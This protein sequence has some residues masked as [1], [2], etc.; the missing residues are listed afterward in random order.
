V[1]IVLIAVTVAVSISIAAW[2]GS[3]TFSFGETK[4]DITVSVPPFEGASHAHAWIDGGYVDTVKPEVLPFNLTFR[5]ALKS[6]VLKVEYFNR[7]MYSTSGNV[8]V[9]QFLKIG[10]EQQFIIELKGD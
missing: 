3:L 9:Y 8:T 6:F 2:M 10:S 7:T 1:A 5:S 4:Q